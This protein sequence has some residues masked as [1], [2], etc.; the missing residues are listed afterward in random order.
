[1]KKIFFSLLAIAA[2]ASCAKTEAVYEEGQVEIKLSPVTAL[3]TKAQV[4]GAIDG[5]TYPTGENFDVFAYWSKDD[6]GMFTD[7]DLFLKNL[8]DNGGA[9][10]TNR[11]NYWGGVVKYYWP[12]NGYLRFAA[13]SPADLMVQHEQVGDVYSIKPYVQPAQTAKTWDFLVA[14]TSPAYSVMTATEKVAVEFEHALSWI[15]L[16]VIAKDGDA[17]Q[18]FDIR[19]VTIK[20]VYTVAN[21][22]ATMLNGMVVDH[23]DVD[24]PWTDWSVAKDYVVFDG[25]QMVTETLTDIENT[26]AGTV[27]IPQ[28]TTRVVVEFDQ[29]GVNGTADTPGMVVELDLVLDTDDTPWVPGKHY[30][31][32]LIFGLDEILINPSV[33]DW[34]D[35]NV[36]DLEADAINVSTAAQLE[37]AL[38]KSGDLK[39]VFQNNI[40][41]DFTVVEEA[42]RTITI[43]GNGYKL[44]GSF[45]LNGKSTYAK[46]TTVFENINFETAD[47]STMTGGSFIYCGEEKGTNYRYP[48]GITVK[49]CTFTA[50]GAAE[51]NA[52]AVKLWALNGDLVVENCKADGLH[53]LLQLTSCGNGDVTVY[54]TEVVNCKNGISL[55]NTGNTTIEK[56][57][58]VAAEYGVRADGANATLTV[59]ES[60]IDAV[61]PIIVRKL[62][63]AAHT[64]NVVLDD[65][66]L[67]PGQDFA[68]V[69]TK[70]SDDVAFVAPTGNFT[71]KGAKPCDSI[72]PETATTKE[73]FEAALTDAN[74]DVIGV[75]ADIVYANNEAVS[76]EKDVT[77]NANGNTIT[78]GGASSLTPS[79]AVMGEYDVV[80][81]DANIEGGFVGAYYGANVTVN[82][83]SLKFTD[84]KSGRNC[85]YAASTDAKPSV[86]TINDV[87]VNMANAS[88]NSYLCAHG[89]A[90]IFVNGGKFYG[91]P[92]GSSNAYVKEASVNGYTGKV[93]IMGGTFNFDPSAWVPAGYEAVKNGSEWTVSA[94]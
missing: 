19:K 57:N 46:A 24:Y 42:A 72:F 30:N 56:S 31:Y 62:T 18:A 54:G 71:I 66:T 77:I 13:Y 23:N 45:F 25:S 88:G 35:E 59:V 58:I 16:K 21:F 86:I 27:V 34:E 87:D 92:V 83:G 61:K 79:V 73:A 68:V 67:V 26:V 9:E 43:D 28:A 65:A 5:T 1:M 39:I 41:G 94:K 8:N 3:Q 7:G 55:G 90:T 89:N 40:A 82:G 48:D 74:I 60:T 6:N 75:G 10:F 76:I 4:L 11:G 69:F 64:Y 22:E 2:I 44:T 51:K 47:A 15:T 37:A 63:N 12:K 29:Y 50:T 33:V 80:L 20:D 53:S 52:V 85:F 14:K 81:N 17:A 36:G 78:A 93:V 70:N 84:G 38:A 49:N 91:K 32:N